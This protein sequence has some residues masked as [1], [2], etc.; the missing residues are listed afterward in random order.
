MFIFFVKDVLKTNLN[1]DI[2][3]TLKRVEPL[4]G[5]RGQSPLKESVPVTNMCSLIIYCFTNREI[6][7][8]AE[9]YFFY[10]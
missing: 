10:A 9:D 2:L 7:I 3:Y 5:L 8:C 1:F 6:S 4:W